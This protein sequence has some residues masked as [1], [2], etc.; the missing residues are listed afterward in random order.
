VVINT[1]VT[2]MVVARRA[3]VE[4]RGRK[5]ASETDT[6][7]ISHL[8]DEHVQRGCGLFEATRRAIQELEGSYSIV[9]LSESEPDRLVAAKSATPIVLG[10][11]EGENFVA[12]DIPALLEHTRRVVFLE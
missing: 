2:E 8:I 11:G 7:V 6:E 9:V 10:L 4:R 5:M 12:S 1:G 3:L